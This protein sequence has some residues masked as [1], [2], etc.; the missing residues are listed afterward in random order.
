M[1]ANHEKE[2][3]SHEY[4]NLTPVA[5]S[6]LVMGL[7]LAAVVLLWIW[8]GHIG[9]SFSSDTLA[10]QQ[11]ILREQYNLPHE[12]I[13]TDPKVLLTPPSLR[14]ITNASDTNSNKST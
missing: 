7:S 6:I 5:W 8:F 11:R 9:P 12:Q 10:E 14:N 2:I 4:H 3:G 1:C 13:I